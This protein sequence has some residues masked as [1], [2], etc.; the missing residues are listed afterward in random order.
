VWKDFSD[1]ASVSFTFTADEEGFLDGENSSI[2]LGDAP[3][4]INELAIDYSDV[5]FDGRR[6]FMAR[7]YWPHIYGNYFSVG[8]SSE[9]VRQDHETSMFGL[10]LA[11]TPS[12]NTN[13]VKTI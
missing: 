9:G 12:V 5:D 11:E 1:N 6:H 13:R 4:G 2:F 3:L 7:I 10:M 8:V